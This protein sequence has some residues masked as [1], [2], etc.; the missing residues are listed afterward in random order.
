MIRAPKRLYPGCETTS[1][2]LLEGK[3][4]AGRLPHLSPPPGEVVG[5]WGLTRSVSFKVELSPQSG[6]DLDLPNYFLFTKLIRTQKTHK[7]G[8]EARFA[9]S[10]EPCHFNPVG[11]RSVDLTREG[12]LTVGV[13]SVLPA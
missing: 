3:V 1:A 5:I 6:G 8:I 9:G 11:P 10:S 7:F 13:P 12:R 2:P 4:Q